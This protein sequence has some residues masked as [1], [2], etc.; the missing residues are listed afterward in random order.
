MR[1]RLYNFCL[2][3]THTHKTKKLKKK[4][5]KR[6]KP[7]T[8]RRK[9]KLL[10]LAV[11]VENL[12]GYDDIVCIFALCNLNLSDQVICVFFKSVLSS[13]CEKT[14]PVTRDHIKFSQMR[15]KTPLEL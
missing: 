8:K 10:L 9:K 12:M 1:F 6:K 5:E 2:K 3:N 11:S 4:R 7:N 14:G 15:N 13:C